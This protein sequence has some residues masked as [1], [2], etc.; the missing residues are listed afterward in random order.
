MHPFHFRHRHSCSNLF[1]LCLYD[2]HLYLLPKHNQSQR[3]LQVRTRSLL[4]QERQLM[5]AAVEV[6]VARC[7]VASHLHVQVEQPALKRVAPMGAR[8]GQA[9]WRTTQVPPLM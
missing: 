7:L 6:G 2:H 1:R 8:R 4:Q 5:S 3:Q 9:P